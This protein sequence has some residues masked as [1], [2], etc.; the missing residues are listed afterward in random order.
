MGL[1]NAI[2]KLVEPITKGIFPPGEDRFEAT[3]YVEF[4][5]RTYNTAFAGASFIFKTVMVCFVIYLMITVISGENKNI[6]QRSIKE[7]TPTLAEEYSK[8]HFSSDKDE[9]WDKL[10]VSERDELR[11]SLHMK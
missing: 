1:F 3:S 4:Q 8:L 9:F 7:H 6:D 11:R 10:S 2:D 5:R